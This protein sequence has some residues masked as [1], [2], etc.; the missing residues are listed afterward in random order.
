M[1]A[2]N[3]A[4]AITFF[5]LL[6]YFPLFRAPISKRTMISNC[7]RSVSRSL[8]YLAANCLPACFDI[9]SLLGVFY[10]SAWI[11]M[12]SIT[13]KPSMLLF[14]QNQPVLYFILNIR[15]QILSCSHHTEVFAKW[16]ITM[17]F[18]RA[19]WRITIYKGR[20]KAGIPMVKSWMKVFSGMAFRMV[21]GNIVILRDSY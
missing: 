8:Y 1:R 7:S 18:T 13:G 4:R 19:R 11:L 21:N 5:P 12:P 10:A 3:R 14:M 6:L 2:R 15:V 17:S 9:I 16:E 20:G